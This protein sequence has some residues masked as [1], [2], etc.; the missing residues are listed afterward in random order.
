LQILS[1]GESPY[2]LTNNGPE[3]SYN[4]ALVMHAKAFAAF[5]A[6]QP[7]M[8]LKL[9]DEGA[10]WG[11]PLFFEHWGDAFLSANDKLKAENAYKKSLELGNTGKSLSLKLSKF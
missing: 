10:K 5:K 8:A 2:P 1:E 6:N 11:T 7:D 4:E 3:D 9:F